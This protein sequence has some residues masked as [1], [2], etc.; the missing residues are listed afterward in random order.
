MPLCPLILSS[1]GS[2]EPDYDDDGE[3]YEVEMGEEEGVSEPHYDDEEEEE[4]EE[5]PQQSEDD[6]EV[7]GEEEPEEDEEEEEEE[8]G[9]EGDD[10]G[11][12]IEESSARMSSPARSTA[13]SSVGR[14]AG[15]RTEA[16]FEHANWKERKLEEKR[17]QEAAK[18]SFAP[19]TNTGKYRGP[20]GPTVNHSRLGVHDRLYES[21]ARKREASLTAKRREIDDREHYGVFSKHDYNK[22]AY[23][24]LASR[25]PPSQPAWQDPNGPGGGNDRTWGDVLD[26]GHP[27]D[28]PDDRSSMHGS[29]GPSSGYG[30][31]RWGGDRGGG[32][33]SGR[34]RSA[35]QSS[36][37]STRRTDA[38]YLESILRQQRRE[39]RV[40]DQEDEHSFQPDLS[41]GRSLY[42]QPFEA[43]S[44][45]SDRSQSVHDRLYDDGSRKREFTQEVV[46]K[47]YSRSRVARHRRMAEFGA[48]G[49]ADE[50]LDENGDFLDEFETKSLGGFSVGGGGSV[51]STHTQRTDALYLEATLRRARREEKASL[52]PAEH[53]FQPLTNNSPFGGIAAVDSNPRAR[54]RS[55]SV[56][57]Y[58]SMS[59]VSG[60]T[61]HDL[62]YSDG[63][64]KRQ[65]NIDARFDPYQKGTGELMGV[66]NRQWSSGARGT[67]SNPL[68]VNKQEDALLKRFDRRHGG[69][70]GGNG[71]GNGVHETRSLDGFSVGVSEAQSAYSGKSHT[72]RTEALYLEASLRAA[73]KEAMREAHNDQGYS[74]QPAIKDKTGTWNKF[75]TRSLTNV[76]QRLYNPA[77]AVEKK[78]DRAEKSAAFEM[79]HFVG[80]PEIKKLPTKVRRKTKTQN[81]S[82]VWAVPFSLCVALYTICEVFRLSS[83]V[84][85]PLF[86][87]PFFSLPCLAQSKLMEK[88]AYVRNHSAARQKE[89]AIRQK[90]AALLAQEQKVY[91]FKPNLVAGPPRSSSTSSRLRARRS[92]DS[93]NDGSRAP[94]TSSSS[95]TSS[96]AAPGRSWKPK[97]GSAVTHPRSFSSDVVT[98]S[99]PPLPTYASRAAQSSSS[100]SFGA[101]AA[102]SADGQQPEAPSSP[103]KS[104]SGNYDA[105]TG[106]SAGAV[107]VAPE[108]APL[109]ALERFRKRQAE[110]ALQQQ[111]QQSSSSGDNNKSA[112]GKSAGGDSSSHRGRENNA[113]EAAAARYR[114]RSPRGTSSDNVNPILAGLSLEDA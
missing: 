99:L 93:T 9:D 16:L 22:P 113:A 3:E 76:V 5:E 56:G 105:K 112:A 11:R 59:D 40:R 1:S 60:I 89:E 47:A 58:R 74:Y 21:S 50:V 53:T 51:T 31:S 20:G 72:R 13:E 78:A 54:A 73:R 29:M 91:T 68:L 32:N 35:S 75:A 27:S 48:D 97:I 25:M 64:R 71:N 65:R 114:G 104:S 52:P 69:N 63:E 28:F 81:L 98:S 37:T 90:A 80:K 61:R 100:S 111:Q 79:R 8:Y 42:R 55:A 103:A 45:R 14:T 36:R 49:N 85:H 26:L 15:T 46:A 39:A 2:E 34:A 87:S 109:T 18:H 108:P 33:H 96:G 77:A 30:G 86:L 92:S 41:R 101:A 102:A 70:G 10:D 12:S 38:L 82:F 84:T 66:Y 4:E 7:D 57:R 83:S 67:S 110:R 19:K 88:D 94:S 6:A 17:A 106:R 24:R 43:T 62:L 44:V 107:A 95:F 23:E